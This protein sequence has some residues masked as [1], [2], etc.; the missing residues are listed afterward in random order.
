M[1]NKEFDRDNTLNSLTKKAVTDVRYAKLL[2]RTIYATLAALVVLALCLHLTEILGFSIPFMS[3]QVIQ[4]LMIG[5][6][7]VMVGC[8]AVLMFSV[9]T[10]V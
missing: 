5:W 10:E 8:I 7:L 9:K 4:Y 3:L 1:T 6:T 2:M